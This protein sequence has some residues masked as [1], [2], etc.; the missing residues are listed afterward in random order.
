MKVSPTSLTA[1]LVLAGAA[2][3]LNKNDFPHYRNSYVGLLEDIYKGG[4]YETIYMRHHK[5][6]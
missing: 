3:G 5:C 2:E 6:V 4:V 1:F